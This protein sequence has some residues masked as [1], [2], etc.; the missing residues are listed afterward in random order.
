MTL[1]DDNIWWQFSM[2]ILV[3]IVIIGIC[4]IWDTYYNIDNWEPGFMTII[5][6]WQ[7]IATL[8]SIRNS[9]DVFVN[10]DLYLKYVSSDL[11]LSRVNPSPSLPHTPSWKKRRSPSRKYSTSS[12]LPLPHIPEEQKIPVFQTIPSA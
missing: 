12:N 8:D 4:D 1:F 3:I 7:L 11:I 9:C 10:N 6:T 2:T 5:V